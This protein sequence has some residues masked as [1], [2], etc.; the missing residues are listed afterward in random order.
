MRIYDYK[1]CGKDCYAN[2]INHSYL[3]YSKGAIQG[4]IFNFNNIDTSKLCEMKDVTRKS[5]LIG[6]IYN[7]SLIC[8]S[9][10]YDFKFIKDHKSVRFP[11]DDKYENLKYHILETIK[12][13]NYKIIK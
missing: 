10:L 1:N 11:F 7:D 3:D 13:R 8:V 5:F 12:P 4:L 6:L 2:A 9:D